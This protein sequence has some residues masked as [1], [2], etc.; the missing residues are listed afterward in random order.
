MSLNTSHSVSIDL[1]NIDL[2]Y[3]STQVIKDVSLSIK[4]GEFF[5][6]LGPSGCGKSTLLRL[7]AG[8]EECQKGEVY[9][10]DQE[11]SMLSS[12]LSRS[13]S[14]RALCR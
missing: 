14:S 1:K 3:G 10:G 13:S 11:V 9:L 8:F 2:S 7:V 6:F 5:A 4:Q 12:G